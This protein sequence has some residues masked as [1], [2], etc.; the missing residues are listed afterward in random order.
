[1]NKNL[2]NSLQEWFLSQ[3]RDFPWREN[4]S[5]YAV[6]VS[7]VMLQQTQA[8]VVTPYFLRWMKRFPTIKALANASIEEVLKEWEGLGYYS[9]ARHL[10]AGARYVVE[11]HEGQLPHD[12]HALKKI[13]GLGAYTI[14]AILSFA[15]HQKQAAVDGNVLRVLTRFY[16]LTDD[17]SKQTTVKKIQEMA[18]NLLPEEEP[19]VVVEALIELGATIC[20][21]SP[22]CTQCPLRAGCAA[23]KQGL[24]NELPIKSV[25]TAVTQLHRAVALITHCDQI[26]VKQEKEG[27]IM[28]DLYEFP[29]FEMELP[30][31][32]PT[33]VSQW[34]R[35]KL[36]IDTSWNGTLQQVKHSFTRFRATLFP[37]IFTTYQTK[38]VSG[39]QWLPIQ[40]L[41]QLPFSAGHRRILASF[42]QTIDKESLIWK[43]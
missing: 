19:W 27:N 31:A 17:I 34:L 23:H 4:P 28:A 2:L 40:Q 10:H 32:D 42:T 33:T 20:S 30:D 43:N 37:H 26:L 38:N 35:E 6:W 21:R 18:Q 41:T 11:N 24:A 14:G 22:K 16:A 8:S 12:A 13:K 5:P 15:F 25:K 3:Q 7:E 1:M 39:Y 29:Y 36:E 9:R